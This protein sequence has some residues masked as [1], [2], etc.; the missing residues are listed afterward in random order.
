MKKNG[1]NYFNCFCNCFFLKLGKHRKNK[2]KENIGK[3]KQKNKEK[4]KENKKILKN[5]LKSFKRKNHFKNS[6]S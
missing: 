4:D 1:F 6:I 5:H 3:E 2:N